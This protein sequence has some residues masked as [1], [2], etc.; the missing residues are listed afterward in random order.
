MDLSTDNQDVN[1]FPS[2]LEGGW[3]ECVKETKNYTLL[4][5]FATAPLA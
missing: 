5:R 3:G 2:K 1:N 4:S